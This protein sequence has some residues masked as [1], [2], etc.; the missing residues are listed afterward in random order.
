MK[1]FATVFVACLGL[2][3]AVA[4]AGDKAWFDMENCAMCQNLSGEPGL[5]DHM[6][7]ENHVISNGMMSFTSVDPEYQEKYEKAKKNMEATG[8]KLMSGEQMNLCGSCMSFG[9]LVMAGVNMEVVNI[10]AGEVM[11]MTSTD[12]A[13]VKKIQD[14]AKK[15]SEEYEKHFAEGDKG[16][17]GHGH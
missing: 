7:W 15:N 5:L 6:T 14:H 17:E 10:K 12:E 2:G 1:T 9:G 13:L 3:L 8:Q 16:H 11:L 4:E